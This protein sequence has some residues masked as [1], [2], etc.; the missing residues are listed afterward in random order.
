MYRRSFETFLFESINFKYNMENWGQLM[1]PK[2]DCKECGTNL[3]YNLVYLSVCELCK[4]KCCRQCYNNA[5]LRNCPMC[6]KKICSYC[7][8]YIYHLTLTYHTEYQY[9]KSHT[10]KEIYNYYINSTIYKE[11]DHKKQFS[12]III[13]TEK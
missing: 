2:D 11:W 3:M 5:L 13:H 4:H 10:Y 1:Y 8:K 7:S 6:S 12:D 9:C